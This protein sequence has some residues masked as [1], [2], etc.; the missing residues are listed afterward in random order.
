MSNDK[1]Y[2]SDSSKNAIR[3]YTPD[4]KIGTL[5]I[6][7]DTDGTGGLLDQPCEVLIR[8]KELIICNFDMPFPGL[9]NTKFDP[10]YT[11]SVINLGA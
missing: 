2:I 7:D 8:G 5:W 11:L 1:I 4:G 6:N 3:Y 9:K 10:P